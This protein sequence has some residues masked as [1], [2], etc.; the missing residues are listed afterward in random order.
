VPERVHAALAE[1]FALT[2]RPEGADGILSLLTTTVDAAYL[3][4]VGAQLRVVANYGVGVDNVDLDAARARNIVVANT[5]DV[6]THPVAELTIAVTLALLRRVAEGDRFI[7]R[8]ER[9]SFSLEFMLGESLRGK[10]FGVVGPG[11]IG[12]TAASLAE[13]LGA[14]PIFAGRGE[15][16][17]ELLRT[18]DVVSLHCPLNEETYHLIDEAALSKMRPTAVLVNTA[19]GPV[20]DE[21]ALADALREGIVAGAALDVFEF[22]PEVTEELLSLDNVVLTP[23]IGSATRST[24]EAMGMLAV[25]ALRTVLL[26][27]EMP[28]NVVR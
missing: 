26:D 5:P 20:V 22:E 1:T 28:A 23:H 8:H 10:T 13:S 11:R 7:R 6:L 16:L 24:R 19:R 12:T 2:N 27:G 14:I 21:R 15:A 17:D 3:D 4:H 18:A 9:W 25:D